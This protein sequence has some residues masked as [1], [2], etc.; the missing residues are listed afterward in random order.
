MNVKSVLHRLNQRDLPLFPHLSKYFKLILI[1]IIAVTSV[2]FVRQVLAATGSNIVSQKQKAMQDGS[3]QESWLFEA[4]GSNAVVGLNILAGTIPDAILNGSMPDV[5]DW[6]PGGAIGMTNNLVA[7][8]YTPP[9][10]GIEY[11]ASTIDGFLGKPAYA[12]GI[13]FKGLEPILPLWRTFRNVVYILSSL[14]FIIIGLMIMLRIKISPQAVIT[15]QSAVPQIITSLVLVTFSYAIAGLIIDLSQFI[16]SLV[17]ALLF[18]STGKG[19]NQP[20]FSGINTNFVELSTRG[21][22]LVADLTSRAAPFWTIALLGSLIG[23]ALG[24]LLGPG[25]GNLIGAGLGFVIIA[26]VF[27]ILMLIWMFKFYF[28]ALKCY[29]TIIFKIIL[30]PLEI[31]MGAFAGSKLNFSTWLLDLV[32]NISVFP[33]TIIFLCVANLIIDSTANITGSTLWTPAIL[34][35][36]SLQSVIT[37]IFTFGSFVSFGIGIATIGILSKLPEMIPQFIF[38][39]KPSPWGTA[40]GETM[41]AVG[42]MGAVEAGMTYG[43][44]YAGQ[45]AGGGVSRLGT[46]IEGIGPRGGA[47]EKLGKAVSGAGTHMKDTTFKQE[48]IDE[49][50]SKKIL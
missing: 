11:I 36:G 46:T 25:W 27:G 9:A 7:A 5:L 38:Q 32:A 44:G 6:I 13:G 34:Y 14:I 19:L 16:Q 24:T 2:F 43:K 35:S 48:N 49:A 22:A 4:A 30:A 3:N 39:I 12:Q 41:G 23:A 28:G 40:I 18:N 20:L 33:I 37:S 31:A 45:L 17:V 42:K 15:I 10:S 47:F 8:L 21:M 50:A 1:T 29:I 26:L